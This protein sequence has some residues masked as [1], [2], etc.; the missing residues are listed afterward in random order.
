LVL[1]DGAVEPRVA[2]VVVPTREGHGVYAAGGRRALGR[3]LTEHLARDFDRV[4]LP[5]SW[6]V[7]DELPRDARGKT[8][9]GALQ[10]IVRDDSPEETKQPRR[11]EVLASH[12]E[13]GL[14]VVEWRVPKD[15]AFLEGHFPGHPV[16]AG[17]VQV[18]WV[19]GVLEESL[20]APPRLAS[21]E[22]LKFHQVLGPGERVRL[23]LETGPDG[24]RFRFTLVDAARPQRTFSSGRG[25]LERQP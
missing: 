13:P 3:Q 6:R 4:L 11:P 16:V 14:T 15:L 5:R 21:L 9:A 22:A 7:V 18:H 2:A 10:A 23:R 24:E 12:R 19:M 20:G 8:A 1:V 17:V 25:L